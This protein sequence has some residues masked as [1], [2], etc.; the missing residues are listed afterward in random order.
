[1]TNNK[2]VNLLIY[3]WIIAPILIIIGCLVQTWLPELNSEYRYMGWMNH[4]KYNFIIMFI[5]LL[6]AVAMLGTVTMSTDKEKDLIKKYFGKKRIIIPAT[7]ISI[8]I[9]FLFVFAKWETTVSD[10]VQAKSVE[11]MHGKVEKI[12]SKTKMDEGARIRNMHIITK[13]TI[14]DSNGKHHQ[15]LTSDLIKNDAAYQ[16]RHVQKNDDITVEYIPYK[17]TSSQGKS[18]GRVLNFSMIST[19]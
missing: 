18:E 17:K 3:T 11:T 8:L 10:A 5:A 4:G 7:L 12:Q 9:C 6:I 16:S 2:W 1:M 13:M 15:L 14:V 19:E